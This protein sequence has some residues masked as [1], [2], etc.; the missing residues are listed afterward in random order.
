MPD[1]DP[2][3]ELAKQA[4]RLRDCE[5]CFIRNI[6][7]DIGLSLSGEEESTEE[8]DH[9]HGELREFGIRIWRRNSAVVS[10]VETNEG[11]VRLRP[12]ATDG[13]LPL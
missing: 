13:P 12:D 2:L 1:C 7:V 6:R 9:P 4:R 8:P 10:P 5:V 3:L 11:S